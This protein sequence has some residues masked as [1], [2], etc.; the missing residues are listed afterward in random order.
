MSRFIVGAMLMVLGLI[1]PQ[2]EA[3]TRL[4]RLP[5]GLEL[6][7]AMRDGLSQQ[8]G[9]WRGMVRN[10]N[11]ADNKMGGTNAADT[12]DGAAGN[13]TLIGYAGFDTYAFE[14]GDGMDTIQDIHPEGNRLLFRGDIQAGDLVVTE[15]E[16]DQGF[17]DRLI[18]YGK[19]DVVRIVNWTGLPDT[20][21]SAWTME[22]MAPVSQEPSTTADAPQD[23]S[24]TTEEI[25]PSDPGGPT[26][27]PIE[28]IVGA[29][30]MLLA[31]GLLFGSLRRNA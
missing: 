28:I 20:T 8:D 18:T 19:G 7:Y 29:I 24:D 2:V 10:G 3:Q 30:L 4:D 26:G 14:P 9:V 31:A 25:A 11:E 17:R 13:D 5:S 1:A 12:L 6:T 22:F 21:R 16:N 27:L 23:Q 15:E